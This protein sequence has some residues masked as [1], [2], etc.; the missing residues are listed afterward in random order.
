MA[1]INTPDTA[2][3]GNALAGIAA[4]FLVDNVAMGGA[5][6]KVLPAELVAAVGFIVFAGVLVY[7]FKQ[8]KKLN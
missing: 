3:I 8:A 7:V 5:V 4:A 1:Q 6:T 2:F